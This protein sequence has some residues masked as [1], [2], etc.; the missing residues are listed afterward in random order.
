[1]GCQKKEVINDVTQTNPV[2]KGIGNEIEGVYSNKTDSDKTSS[3]IHDFYYRDEG[4]VMQDTEFFL[5]DNPCIFDEYI[6]GIIASINGDEYT[7]EIGSHCNDLDLS[8]R[9]NGGVVLLNKDD[10][11][12]EQFDEVNF[13]NQ[14]LIY[15]DLPDNFEVKS[16]IDYLNYSTKIEIKN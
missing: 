12:F 6:V 9:V 1:M 5:E 8:T 3:A 11:P 7:I 2:N 16:Y 10:I 15:F 4:L 13:F 14:V